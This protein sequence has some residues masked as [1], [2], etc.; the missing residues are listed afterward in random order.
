MEATEGFGETRSLYY[1]SS[2]C[3]APYFSTPYFS[4]PK[5][6]TPYFGTPYFGT[7]YFGNKHRTPSVAGPLTQSWRYERAFVFPGSLTGDNHI[8]KMV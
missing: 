3:G 8:A 6:G 5:F 4:T 2:P 1:N 7:P